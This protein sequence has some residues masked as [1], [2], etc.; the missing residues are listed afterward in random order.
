MKELFIK[1]V[2]TKMVDF[3]D[4]NQRIRLKEILTEICLNYQI[5]I[6]EQTKRQ[7]TQKNNTD[8]LDRFIASKEIE[9]CS[10]RTLKYYKDNITKMFHT[11]NLPISEI[12]TEILR[13]YLANY[14]S[15]SKASMVTIDNIRRTLSSF[16]TW[17]ENE[18]YVKSPVRRIHKVKAMKKVKETLT[19]ENLEKLRDTCTNVRDLAILEL[20]IST[21]M[22]VG[23]LTRLNISDMNFQERSCIVLGKG[24]SE[25]E[26]YFS[27]KSKM[28]IENKI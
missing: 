5:E 23:E 7:E 3:L 25:R 11:V 22:R 20:L 17:L 8:I 6:I 28:Y 2:T 10:T 19:D 27:A 24:N 12:N 26:V 18:D 14:K 16:F 4:D 21:G 9:G 15:N 13:N 1:E